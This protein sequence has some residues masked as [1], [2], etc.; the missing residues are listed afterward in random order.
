ME[1]KLDRV[2]I[3]SLKINPIVLVLYVLSD[4]W[5][6]ITL[7]SGTST[8]SFRGL[9]AYE[10]LLQYYVKGNLFTAPL[11]T[12]VCVRALDSACHLLISFSSYFE[13]E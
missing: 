10:L 11:Y 6:L 7:Y 1:H 2:Q 9:L 4:C 5:M 12:S 8:C 3:A 13:V